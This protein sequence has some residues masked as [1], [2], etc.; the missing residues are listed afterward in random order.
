MTGNGLTEE[1]VGHC[2]GD[3]GGPLICNDD[4]RPVVYGIVSWNDDCAA[5]GFPGIYAK[6]A[7]E[8]DWIKEQL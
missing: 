8:L 3:S 5:T 2:S 6:V 7:S 4:G 1:G